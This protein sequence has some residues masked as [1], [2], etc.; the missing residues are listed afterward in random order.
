MPKKPSF[1]AQAATQR[2]GKPDSAMESGLTSRS[3]G[4]HSEED[5]SGMLPYK[6]QRQR[7]MSRLKVYVGVPQARAL[8]QP[9]S[10]MPT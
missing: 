2:I 4:P 10:Q 9:P 5:Y 7:Q 3:V 6:K 8:R 1:L